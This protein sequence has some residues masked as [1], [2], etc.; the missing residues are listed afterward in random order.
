M[1]G[2]V[3]GP[4]RDAGVLLSGVLIEIA[5]WR[6]VFLINLPIA[7]LALLL[8][9]R[10]INADPVVERRDRLDL[11]GA[12][13]L[14]LGLVSVIDGVLRAAEDGWAAAGVIAR[15]AGGALRCSGSW[16][17][18]PGLPDRWCR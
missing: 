8:V 14:T 12:I 18:R 4:G 13:L 2:R 9:P 6:W 17:W 5:N 7:V 10:L 15:L 11:P 3:G 1:V 16:W